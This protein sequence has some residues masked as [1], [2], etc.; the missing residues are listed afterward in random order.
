MPKKY[1]KTFTK[2]DA[3]RALDLGELGKVIVEMKQCDQHFIEAHPEA[4]IALLEKI[5]YLRNEDKERDLRWSNIIE[6]HKF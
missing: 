6:A 2:Y 1:P 3:Q 5:Q 4:I